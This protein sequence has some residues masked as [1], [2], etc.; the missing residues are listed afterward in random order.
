[1]Q[2]TG[3]VTHAL[4]DIARTLG[5]PHRLALLEHIA[6]GERS[7][8]ALAELCGLS[9]ANASQHLQHLRRAG[10]AARRRDGKRVLYRLGGGPIVPLLVA[11]RRCAE[12]GDRRLRGSADVASAAEGVS[13]Q[14][15]LD[16]MANHR[17]VLIDVRAAEEFALGHLPGAINLPI[18]TLEAR[19]GEL[20]DD[21]EIVAYCRGP[22]CVLSHEAVALLRGRGVPARRL[23][24]GFMDWRA[25][26]LAVERTA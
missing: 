20:P 21:R 11:L 6:Q 13:R 15:L 17:V 2:D 8:E 4:S 26:G 22:Y 9:L 23:E 16:R 10:L 25:A 18:D 1:M 7:V 5:H 14:E 24:D 12:H 3:L 19:L